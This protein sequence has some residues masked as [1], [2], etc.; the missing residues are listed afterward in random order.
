MYKLAGRKQLG[1]KASHRRALV[2]NQ[3]RSLFQNGHVSTT[4]S[5]ALVLKANADSLLTK[6]TSSKNELILTRDL[7]LIFDNSKISKIAVDYAN[8]SDTGVRIVKVGFRAGDN[9]EISKVT[10]MNFVKQDKKKKAVAKKSE[11]KVAVAEETKE[12]ATVNPTVKTQEK[13]IGGKLAKSFKSKMP[14]SKERARSRS[15]L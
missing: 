3:L 8:Q 15:G 6:I 9:A 12:A 1:R 7:A 2:T 13:G 4:S 14:S 11:K 10:L 5:K